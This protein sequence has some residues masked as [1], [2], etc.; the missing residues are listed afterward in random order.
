V[1]V[2]AVDRPNSELGGALP[3]TSLAADGQARHRPL[4]GLHSDILFW[5]HTVC[6]RE[7][8]NSRFVELI[9][10]MFVPSVSW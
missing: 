4:T 2:V 1:V 9:F 7:E 3:S 6:L 10:P 8:N 5:P